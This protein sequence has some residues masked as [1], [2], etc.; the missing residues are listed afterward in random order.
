MDTF[1]RLEWRSETALGWAIRF[2]TKDYVNHTGAI[3]KFYEYDRVFTIE[4]LD[5]GI[6]M[7]KLS[8]RLKAQKG[9]C[10]WYPLKPEYR[11]YRKTLGQKMLDW[12]YVKYDYFSLFKQILFRATADASK[13]FCSEFYFLAGIFHNP[14]L[15][16]PEIYQKY[17]PRPG[18]EMDALEW[19]EKGVRVLF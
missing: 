9:Y 10:V 3:I 5:Y 14:P 17:A 8:D 18:K 1:D 13:M 12:A 2:M 15:P 4:A 6:E 16:Y 11:E 19:N 7:N